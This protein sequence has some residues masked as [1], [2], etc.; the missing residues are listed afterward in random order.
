MKPKRTFN[1]R[2]TAAAAIFG[3]LVCV[4]ALFVTANSKP[5]EKD[6][7]ITTLG[8]DFLVYHGTAADSA[9][10]IEVTDAWLVGYKLSDAHGGMH[11][12]NRETATEVLQTL[13]EVSDTL[14]ITESTDTNIREARLK[15]ETIIRTI[16]ESEMPQDAST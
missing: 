1:E 12:M 11:T 2:L 16:E 14:E 3:A 9:E 15:I 10:G 5:K 7:R 13:R 4:T 6:I 8:G